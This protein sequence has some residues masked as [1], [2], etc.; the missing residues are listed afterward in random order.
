MTDGHDNKRR[1]LGPPS[2]FD[3]EVPI[4]SGGRIT[5][6]R[7][8]MTALGL[9]EGH[10]VLLHVTTTRVVNGRRTVSVDLSPNIKH[11]EEL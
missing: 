8:V 2:S 11:E 3:I 6:P 1:W 5:I 10:T 4:I 7:R 9:E